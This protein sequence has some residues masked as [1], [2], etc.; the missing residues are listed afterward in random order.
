MDPQPTATATEI[1]IP[2]GEHGELALELPRSW[3]PADVIWPRLEGALADYPQ[4]LRRALDH[5]EGADRLESRVGPGV[6]VAIVVDDP[7]R[8]TPVVEA[9][10]IVLKRLHDAGVRPQDVTISVGVGRH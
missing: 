5:P 3:Q 9:L 8:W 1:A 6:T 4:A 7:S 2:W 10:P